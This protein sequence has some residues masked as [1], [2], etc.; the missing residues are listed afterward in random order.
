MGPVFW[1]EILQHQVWVQHFQPNTR[2]G[3]QVRAAPRHRPYCCPSVPTIAPLPRFPHPLRWGSKTSEIGEFKT[4]EIGE[5]KTSEIGEFN[6]LFYS[7]NEAWHHNI[8]RKLLEW[9]T[10]ASLPSWKFSETS[11][12]GTKKLK[13]QSFLSIS[14]K[15]GTYS[16]LEEASN[17]TERKEMKLPTFWYQISLYCYWTKWGWRRWI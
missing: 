7:Q 17:Y 9:V 1:F 15:R 10:W 3:F 4:S 5:F 14:A 8:D 6:G 12:E 11:F 13:V 2:P 16:C